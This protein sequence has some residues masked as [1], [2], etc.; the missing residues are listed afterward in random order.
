M[1]PPTGGRKGRPYMVFVHPGP[2]DPRTPGP[3]DPRTPGPQDPSLRCTAGR[4]ASRFSLVTRYP[5]PWGSCPTHP[6][7]CSST[8]PGGIKRKPE[9]VR[10]FTSR[11]HRSPRKQSSWPSPSYRPRGGGKCCSE[12]RGAVDRLS[13]RAGSTLKTTKLCRLQP[14]RTVQGAEPLRTRCPHD[15]VIPEGS[16]TGV[17]AVFNT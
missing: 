6:A 9:L 8:T 1:T 13:K 3:Q 14:L 16:I 11:G 12:H 15:P 5:T 2:Q 7:A 10:I 4:G 17:G